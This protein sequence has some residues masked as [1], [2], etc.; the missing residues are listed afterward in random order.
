MALAREV[1]RRLSGTDGRLLHP[2]QAR[3]GSPSSLLANAPT[4]SSPKASRLKVY[5]LSRKRIFC[6]KNKYSLSISR[7]LYKEPNLTPSRVEIFV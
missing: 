7:S 3:H 4:P 1:E 2:A 6:Q 5:R